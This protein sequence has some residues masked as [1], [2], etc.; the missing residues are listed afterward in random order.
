MNRG[1][2]QML[3]AGLATLVMCVCVHLF[4]EREHALA[5]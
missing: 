1:R 3:L 2:R 4:D 5:R